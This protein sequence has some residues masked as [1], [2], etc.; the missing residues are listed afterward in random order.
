MSAIEKWV[1]WDHAL[2]AWTMGF[3][4]SREQAQ[5]WIDA[6]GYADDPNYYPI[7]W[8]TRI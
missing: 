2:D 7:Q 3:F 6:H 1:I 5:R 4:Y 8:E